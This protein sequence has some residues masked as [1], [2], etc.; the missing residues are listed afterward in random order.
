LVAA[1]GIDDDNDVEV[2]FRDLLPFAVEDAM[3]V[4]G[5]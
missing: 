2:T 1:T 4:F 5:S 3:G